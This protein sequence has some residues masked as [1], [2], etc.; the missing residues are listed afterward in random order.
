[1][2]DDRGMPASEPVSI[3]D[4]VAYGEGAIVS[5]TILDRPTGTVTL[6]AFDA[7]QTISEHTT[8]FDA[9]VQVMAGTIRFTIGGED[10]TAGAGQSVLMPADIPHALTAESQAKMLLTMI[11]S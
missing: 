3:P 11:R 5:R 8:P 7:G 10:M 2:P 9:L 6:F 1:M 4:L